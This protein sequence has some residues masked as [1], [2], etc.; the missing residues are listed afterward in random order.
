[1]PHVITNVTPLA[2]RYSEVIG[3]VLVDT[4]VERWDLRGPGGGE[5]A[6]VT[7]TYN[8]TGPELP[9]NRPVIF[10]FNGGPGAS[11]GFLGSGLLAPFRIDLPSPTNPPVHGPFRLVPNR[12]HLLDAADIVL[13][14]PPGTGLTRVTEHARADFLGVNQDADA[15]LAVIRGWCSRMGRDGSP[16]YL[17]GESY[18]SIRVATIL[19]RSL[20]GPTIGGELHGTAFSGAIMVG[21]AFDLAGRTFGDTRFVATFPTMAATA[22][23]HGAIEQ[24]GSLS[25]HVASASKFA[26]EE[27]VPLYDRGR[28]L[29]KQER[30]KAAHVMSSFIGLPANWIAAH[31]LRVEANEYAV[32]LLAENG[33][34]VGAYDSRFAAPLRTGTPQAQPGDPVAD[35]SAMG[36]YT[37]SFA[38][39]SRE[40]LRRGGVSDLADY[41]MIDFGNVNGKWDWGHGP[42]KWLPIDPIGFLRRAIDLDPGF[43][44]LF[45]S[46]IYDFVTPIESAQ[47]AADHIAYDPSRVVVRNYESGHMPYIGDEPRA[48]ISADIRNFINAQ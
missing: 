46:G 5:A 35:D 6:A 26:R 36:R 45:A 31:D 39:A 10:A 4:Q 12:E 14:D 44:L 42:G 40:L 18:G 24:V 16:L 2:D 34:Q 3:D 38:W 41:R 33:L 8:R 21:G 27:L 19:S 15:A 7:T 11:S 32:Q 17:L 22:W 47:I 13:V 30:T 29:E 23:Y 43:R 20:G 28:R 48:A 37:H 1:M 9:P 25:E